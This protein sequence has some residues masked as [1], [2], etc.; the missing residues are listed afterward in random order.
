LLAA[1]ATVP[2]EFSASFLE[3]RLG[4]G[5][6][7]VDLLC[8][9]LESARAAI[10]ESADVAPLASP[11]ARAAFDAWKRPGTSMNE[12]TPLLWLE[13]D[14][15]GSTPELGVPSV[16]FCLERRYLQF[17]QFGDAHCQEWKRITSEVLALPHCP[18]GARASHQALERCFDELRAGGGRAIHLSIMSGRDPALAKLYVRVPTPTALL[19]L[20]RIGWEGD[21]ETVERFLAGLPAPSHTFLDLTF[22]ADRTLAHLGL[23]FPAPARKSAFDASLFGYA[24]GFCGLETEITT[25]ADELD[26]WAKRSTTL[27]NRTDWPTSV[28][29]WID[30]KMVFDEDGG[31]HLKIYFGLRLL[32]ALFGVLREREPTRASA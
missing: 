8:C 7:R 17:R 5:E 3:C 22:S 19:F 4:R 26:D 12:I 27:C 21:S 20:E 6:G 29:R 24:A 1:A 2:A 9:A 25:I 32:P 28:Q 11:F 18:T 14:D 10:S 31:M 15:A 30:Q 16:C 23:A 13:F